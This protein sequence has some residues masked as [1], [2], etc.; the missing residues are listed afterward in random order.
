MISWCCLHHLH[1]VVWRILVSH[2]WLQH[3]SLETS[4]T[5]MWLLMRSLI[6]GQVT[7]QSW[8]FLS[9]QSQHSIALGNLIT[10]SNFEHFWLNE[11]FTVFIERKIKGRLRGEAERHF[12]TLL[13]SVTN[14]PIT[15]KISIYC[16]IR[17]KYRLTNQIVQME[18]VGRVCL[19]RVWSRTW[20]HQADSKS[21]WCWSWWCVL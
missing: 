21:D 5:L 17:T 1:S 16:S 14:Q 19:W 13:R 6:P 20:V 12:T 18:G 9:D 11:G 15:V 8:V 7:N 4:Q 2:L 10:N 3:Y